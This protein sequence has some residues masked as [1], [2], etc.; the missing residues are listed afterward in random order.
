[1]HEA[2]FLI[3]GDDTLKDNSPGEWLWC[4]ETCTRHE[5]ELKSA[6]AQTL[7]ISAHT[8]PNHSYQDECHSE[9]QLYNILQVDGAKSLIG[10]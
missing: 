5:F 9:S 7:Y 6:D 8:W 3:L 1:M 4:G 2:H 10:W